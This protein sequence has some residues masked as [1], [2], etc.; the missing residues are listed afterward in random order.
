M[1][2]VIAYIVLCFMS[3]SNLQIAVNEKLKEG[4]IPEGGISVGAAPKDGYS[5]TYC[6]AM[7]RFAE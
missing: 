4:W 1:S 5:L 3:P 2:T 7:D 6:Q